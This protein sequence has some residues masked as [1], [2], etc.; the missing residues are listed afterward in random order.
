MSA[1]S[2]SLPTLTT[3]RT[4][5]IPDDLRAMRRWVVARPLTSKT[6]LCAKN[7]TRHAR[8]TDPSTWVAFETAQ[9]ALEQDSDLSLGFVFAAG[10]GFI[11]VDLDKC[12][13]P[14]TGAVEPWAEDIVNRLDRYTETSVSGTGLHIICKGTLPVGGR[15]KGRIEMYEKARFFVMTGAGTNGKPI[16]ERTDALA[17]LHAEV[18]GPVSD[19]AP[20]T[21]PAADSPVA[22]DAAS[23]DDLLKRIRASSQGS[24]FDELWSGDTSAYDGDDSRADAAL[25]AILAFWTGG[26]RSQIDRLFR[27]SGLMRAKWERED[28]RSRSISLAIKGMQDRASSSLRGRAAPASPAPPRFVFRTREM[29]MQSETVPFL[30]QGILVR[31][32]L[33]ALVA[34]PGCNKTFLAL[35]LGLSVAS[36]QKTW[37]GQRLNLNGPV[38][39]VLGEGD[40]R[41]KLRLMAWDERHGVPTTSRYPFSYVNEP[42]ALT[43]PVEAR[44][45]VDE[46][47]EKKPV[48]IIF[49]TLRRCLAGADEN[50]QK[51]MSAAMAVC[52]TLRRQLDCCVLLVHH[53]KKDGRAERGS[54]VLKCAVD[55]M[56]VLKVDDP[57][58]AHFTMVC[59]KQKD[60]DHFAPIHLMRERLT[61]LS[62][63]DPFTG[64]PAVSCVVAVAPGP[65]SLQHEEQ[66]LWKAKTYLIEN[67][68]RSKT[69]LAGHL[70]GRKVDTLRLIEKWVSEGTIEFTRGGGRKGAT[71]RKGSLDTDTGETQSGSQ[72]GSHESEREP[73]PEPVPE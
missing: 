7:V 56:L 17:A 24:K 14:E 57:S 65:P 70:K 5:S 55:T 37:L 50:S 49:D 20:A 39:Y 62:A 8:V 60:A 47:A 44:A 61:L 33:V 1:Q 68:G 23:D 34:P 67:P 63:Q 18:F 66:D 41:F 2:L 43:H 59:D 11:G 35:D 16:T 71:S 69:A 54:S 19:R 12:C 45:F 26:D 13:N 25:C 38:V 9:R 29:L 40:G 4:G 42:V 36:G 21:A 27:K 6:P 64:E 3:D 28:Y 48:L 46:V 73:F 53:T 58:K 22:S 72:T 32:S 31:K 30:V 15:R 52:D 10:D 51:D